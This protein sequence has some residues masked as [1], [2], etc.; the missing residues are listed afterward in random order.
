MHEGPG[1][2]VCLPFVNVPDKRHAIV[3]H[4]L[5]DRVHKLLQVESAAVKFLD[6]SVDFT[7]L[8]VE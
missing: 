5:F 1:L 8:E 7:D 6:V 4:D 3:L 2:S